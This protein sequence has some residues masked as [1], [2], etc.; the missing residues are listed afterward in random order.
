ME[1]PETRYVERPDGVSIAYQV[2]GDGPRDLVYVPGFISHLDLAWADPGLTRF[3]GRLAD[4]ARVIVFDKP[5]TGVSDPIDHVP[6][7]EE[8]IADVRIVLDAAGSERA[9]LLGFSEGGPTC[10]LFAATWPERVDALV[11]YGSLSKARPL[12]DELAA[13][14]LPADFADQKWERIDEVT[15]R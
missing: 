5:G 13:W 2:F 4:L 6:T 10:V 9:V 11:L 7:L 15:R 3:Y 8:R 12:A 1:A 14:G